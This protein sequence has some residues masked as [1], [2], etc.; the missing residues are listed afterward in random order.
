MSYEN[1]N[2]STP[3]SFW[4]VAKLT[5]FFITSVVYFASHRELVSCNDG[6]QFALS[7]AMGQEFRFAINSFMHYT[8][9]VDFSFFQ[10]NFL[11][12]RAPGT[13]LLTAPLI[14]IV[15]QL[16][17]LLGINDATSLESIAIYVSYA[18]IAAC[19]AFGVIVLLNILEFH[20]IAKKISW[21]IALIFAFATVHWKY[22]TIYMAHGTAE[23]VALLLYWFFIRTFDVRIS[24]E[25][26]THAAYFFCFLLGFFPSVRFEA[27][28]VSLV[29]GTSFMFLI[30]R[31]S[32]QSPLRTRMQWFLAVLLGVVPLFFLAYYHTVCFGA[33]WHTFAAYYHPDRNFWGELQSFVARGG[34]FGVNDFIGHPLFSGIGKVL[35]QFPGTVDLLIPAKIGGLGAWGA[36]ILQPVLFLVPLGLIPYFMRERIAAS[37]AMISFLGILVFCGL[38][39]ALDGG[40]MRDPRY[41][42]PAFPFL[43]IVLAYAASWW[44]RQEVREWLRVSCWIAFSLLSSAGLLVCFLHLTESDGSYYSLRNELSHQPSYASLL[45]KEYVVSILNRVF[46]APFGEAIIPFL[47]LVAALY[48]FIIHVGKYFLNIKRASLLL[49]GINLFFTVKMLFVA[50]AHLREIPLYSDTLQVSGLPVHQAVQEK[51]WSRYERSDS[52]RW[53]SPPEKF[54]AITYENGDGLHMTTDPIV[55]KTQVKN[56]LYNFAEKPCAEGLLVKTRSTIQ[57]PLNER[58]VTFSTRIGRTADIITANTAPIRFEVWGDDR[59]LFSSKS[60][61]ISTPPQAVTLSVTNIKMLEL[62]TIG[63]G[64]YGHQYGIWCDAQLR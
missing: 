26:R 11:S 9:R 39:K 5:L 33:P 21:I 56:A 23:V 31:S 22:A 63:E 64:L 18:A 53:F 19:S 43:F 2:A 61:D 40:A 55:T 3:P 58:F 45:S 57:V 28:I 48:F 38:S 46:L 25:K 6:S 44:D 49:V 4:S 7:R 50:N 10:G 12:D 30:S 32:K 42:M 13:S 8:Q 24:D 15:T 59:F 52:S 1:N 36:T 27:A 54:I 29:F 62:R 16:N 20:G 35:F 34:Q 17:L 37:T 60:Y 41:I 51:D 47:L 14:F